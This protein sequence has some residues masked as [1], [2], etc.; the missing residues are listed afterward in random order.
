MSVLQKYSRKP[1]FD[2]DAAVCKF[3]L[4]CCCGPFA[5]DSVNCGIALAIATGVFTCAI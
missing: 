1:A 2:S 3:H 4:D 5:F